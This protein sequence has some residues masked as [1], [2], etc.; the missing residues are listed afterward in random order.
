MSLTRKTAVTLFALNDIKN[1]DLII[2][3]KGKAC[4]VGP[5][6]TTQQAIEGPKVDGIATK[7]APKGTHA[8]VKIFAY[9]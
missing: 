6:L 1:R 8:E 9:F 3:K 5:K 4:S 2:I 7:D